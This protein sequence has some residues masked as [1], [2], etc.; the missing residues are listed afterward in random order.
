MQFINFA[1]INTFLKS[2]LIS[3]FSLI[4]NDVNI[5]SGVPSIYQA[6]SVPEKNPLSLEELIFVWLTP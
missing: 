1:N 4:I 2:V 5:I 6:V 3:S